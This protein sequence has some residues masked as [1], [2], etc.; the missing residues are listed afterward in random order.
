MRSFPRVTKV[1]DPEPTLEYRVAVLLRTGAALSTAVVLVGGLLFLSRHSHQLLEYH[2]FRGEPRAL[3]SPVG[4]VREVL[5]PS[6]RAIIDLGLLLLILTPVSRVA[7]TLIA[8]IRARDRLYTAVTA[9]VLAVL[10]FSL[11]GG[12][13]WSTP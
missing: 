5:R 12:L 11:L 3:R 10:L 4:I 8:F 6:G 7:F 13:K 9:F 2:V 1:Q